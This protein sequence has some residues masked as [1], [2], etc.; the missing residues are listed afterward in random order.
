MKQKLGMKLFIAAGVGV[1]IIM[2]AV[3]ILKNPTNENE[4][5]MKQDVTVSTEYNK[6]GIMRE[7]TKEELKH[8][9]AIFETMDFICTKYGSGAYIYDKYEQINKDNECIYAINSKTDEKLCVTR[10]KIN[11]EYIYK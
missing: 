10:T 4:G 2:L 5:K 6:L 11:D 3:I 9:E 7:L 1:V 8:K